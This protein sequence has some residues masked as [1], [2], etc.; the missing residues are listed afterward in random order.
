MKKLVAVLTVLCLLCAAFSALAEA[1]AEKEE[2]VFSN[3]VKFGM[4]EDEV[5]AIEG[6][7]RERDIDHTYGSVTFRTL[8]YERVPD[9]LFDNKAVDRDYLFVDGKLVAVRIGLHTWDVP[10]EKVK[11]TL[12]AHGE[13]G[14]LDAAVIG[15]GIYAVDDDGRAEW[16]VAALVDGNVM[17]VLE[18]DEDGEDI[19]VTI[20]DLTAAYIK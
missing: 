20:V 18:L 17:T 12:A 10:Y 5:I 2:L 15:N 13:F 3:G 16:N 19:D 9:P 1:T 14:N 8:E 7:P 4:T 6:N 11:S